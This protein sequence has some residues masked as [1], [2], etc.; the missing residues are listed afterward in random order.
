MAKKE[1]IKI[2]KNNKRIAKNNLKQ[3]RKYCPNYYLLKGMINGYSFG[4]ELLE[5]NE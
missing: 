2:L 1:I 4:V 5:K 3:Q